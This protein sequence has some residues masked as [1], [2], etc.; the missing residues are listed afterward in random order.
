MAILTTYNA[1]DLEKLGG[2]ETDDKKL[3]KKFKDK[4]PGFE[5]NYRFDLSDKVEVTHKESGTVKKILVSPTFYT[6]LA[7]FMNNPTTKKKPE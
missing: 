2:S 3:V 6:D 1:S 7:N 5:F 4:Y